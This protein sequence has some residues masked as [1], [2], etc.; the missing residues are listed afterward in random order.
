ML[1]AAP[2]NGEPQNANFTA[3]VQGGIHV[4]RL[5]DLEALSGETQWKHDSLDGRPPRFLPA[6]YAQP[7]GINGAA[8]FHEAHYVRNFAR[9]RNRGVVAPFAMDV[10]VEP[11]PGDL[12]PPL[13][14][15]LG[16]G[17]GPNELATF[18]AQ[19]PL[20]PVGRPGHAPLPTACLDVKDSYH[21]AKAVCDYAKMKNQGG[22]P[23]A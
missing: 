5:S 19:A 7:P 15:P 12:P 23:L 9:I 10:D 16:T 6:A 2:Q 18:A 11:L 13:S 8:S 4:P 1:L 17:P 21:Y 22:N 20:S 14:L 3:V